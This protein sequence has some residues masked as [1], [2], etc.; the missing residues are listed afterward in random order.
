L[1]A[2]DGR[3]H[4][5]ATATI[6][7][8]MV[9]RMRSKVGLELRID[10]STNNAEATRFA[11]VRFAEGIGD[12]NPLWVDPDYAAGSALGGLVAPP[13]WVFCCFSGI[14]FGWPGLGA[15]HSGSELIAHRIVRAGD[16][17]SAR[18]VYDGFDGPRPSSFAGQ[19]IVDRF[20][21]EYRNQSGAL[22]AEHRLAV[23]RFERR[24]ARERLP[25]R[26]VELP[27][28]WTPEELRAIDEDVL[29]ERP[30]GA[31]PRW[32]DDV[33]VGDEVDVTTKGPL[34]LTDE[35]AYVASGAAPV[36]RLAA[37]GAALRKYRAQP[38]WAFRDPDTHAWEPLYAVHYN[39]HAARQM[40]S[41]VPYDVGIQ[42]MCWQVHGLT[43]W[44]GD[45]AF[46][47]RASAEFRAFVYLSDVVRLGGR[48]TGKF[49]EDDG[50][51]VVAID[52]WG[53]NQRGDD[54]V[55]GSALVALPARDGRDPLDGR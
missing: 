38:K 4:E 11:I 23:T 22:V 31:E 7:D 24:Q 47:K 32:W 48:V 16:T 34:G 54:V 18:C 20:R 36:P 40:G 12:D 2:V 33:E 28:P 25:S 14:Q 26:R 41:A 6:T 55:P 9:E 46:I 10:G 27:H 39:G 5:M 1:T 19:A 35:V 42:R 15:V 50:D 53:T 45:R 29:A 52:T 3:E 13:T 21:V 49:E 37:H 30:R 17:I 43:N 44:A 8:E 51:A